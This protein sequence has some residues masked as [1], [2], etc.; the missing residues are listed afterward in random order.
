MM[1]LVQ[2]LREIQTSPWYRCTGGFN[3]R[4]CAAALQWAGRVMRHGVAVREFIGWL[5]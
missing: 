3:A 2:S 4:P 1:A 5:L